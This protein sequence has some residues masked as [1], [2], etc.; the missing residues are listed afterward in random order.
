MK[1]EFQG[2]RLDA[3]G[4]P[5]EVGFPIIDARRI[6]DVI[7][8]LC[9]WMAFPRGEPARNLFGFGLNGE[10]LWRAQDIG[11]HAIDAYTDIV[12]EVPLSVFNYACFACTIDP[13]SGEV[14]AKQFTK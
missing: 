3:P 5:I 7:V 8:V 9:D 10:H 11:M 6:E 12:A 14:L 4:G 2:S 1:L 13:R